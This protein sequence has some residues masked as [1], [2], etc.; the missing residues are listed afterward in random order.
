[1]QILEVP[2]VLTEGT[3]LAGTH[4]RVD[5]DWLPLSWLYPRGLPNTVRLAE[6]PKYIFVAV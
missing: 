1:M 3:S 4:G 2:R 6:S 5:V